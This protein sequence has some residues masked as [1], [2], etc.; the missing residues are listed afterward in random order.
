MVTIALDVTANVLTVKVADASPPFTRTREGTTAIAGSE[1]ARATS[2]PPFGADPLSVTV[3]TEMPPPATFIGS[4]ASARSDSVVGGVTASAA[5]CESPLYEALTLMRADTSV[6]YVTI[7]K[8]PVLT[9]AAR[10]TLTGTVAIDVSELVRVMT[11]PPT[12]AGALRVT[13]PVADR[14]PTT[15]DGCKANEAS[16]TGGGRMLKTADTE[17]PFALTDN[18]AVSVATTGVVVIVKLALACPAGTVTSAGDAAARL[19]DREMATRK[20]AG[21]VPLKTTEAFAELPPT[22]DG[23]L[24]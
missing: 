9:P 20:S 11:A 17:D 12:G 16:V 19:P 8:V 14:P 2:T 7:A 15:L 3:P 22:T 24:S 4:T 6:L 1:L 23:G 13:T 21:V 10:M 18:V 5:L